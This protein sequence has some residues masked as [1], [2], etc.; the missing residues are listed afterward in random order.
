MNLSIAMMF[1]RDAIYLREWLEF[2]RLIG[3][4]KFYLYHQGTEP[5]RDGWEKVLQ[6]Y[7]EQ[8][9][10]D[11]K[12]WPYAFYHSEGRNAHIDANQDCIDRLKGKDGWLAFVDSD[13]F[14]FSPRYDT[15]TEALSTLPESWG[16]VGVHW[17][18]FGSSG[19]QEWEDAP[20]IERF[21]WRPHEGLH[22]N[23][24]VKSIVRLNDPL[25]ATIG[26]EH[27]FRTSGGTYDEQGRLLT[28]EETT[29]CSSLLRL[30]HYFTKSR[31][32]WEERHP[33]DFSGEVIPRDEK[34]WAVQSMD[35]D[36]RTIWKFL[37]Q[38]RERMK[39][40]SIHLK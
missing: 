29:P 2:H 21:T 12:R 1:K 7:I 28:T 39:Q 20:V 11:L 37:P 13:E 26:S 35:V 17:M 8:G 9:I 31:K 16:A 15:V 22:F 18:M 36:D 5:A 19:K 4:S 23:N 24:W 32:E 40:C 30:N 3:V 25:L 27:L 6:P 10:V 14:L 38:L 34:R 33:E